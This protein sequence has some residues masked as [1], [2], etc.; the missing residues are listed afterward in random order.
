MKLY[1]LKRIQRFT[2]SRDTVFKFFESP[3]HLALITPPWLDFRILT[4]TPITMRQ[5]TLIDYT[6][7]WLTVPVRWT[8]LITTY[9]HPSR[10]VDEQIRGPYVLWHHSH[11]FVEKDGFTEMH[12]E[13]RYALPFGPLGRIAHAALVGKQLEEIFDYRSAVIGRFLGDDPA[14]MDGETNATKRE[15]MA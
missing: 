15:S 14:A 9:E 1:T 3:E 10:F 6:I 5:G 2:P 7:H 13:V 4:P 11:T 12:D 8:T